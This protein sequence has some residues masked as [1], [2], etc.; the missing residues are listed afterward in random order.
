MI[1]PA[2]ML[3]QDSQTF[4]HETLDTEIL[5]SERRRIS[6]VLAFLAVACLTFTALTFFPGFLDDSIRLKFLAQT[7]EVAL[8]FSIALGY[9][10]AVLSWIGKLLREGSKPPHWLRYANTFI[11]NV[12]P[13]ATLLVAS[14]VFGPVEALSAA[15]TRFYFLFITMTALQLDFKVCLVAGVTAAVQYSAAAWYLLRNVDR[16]VY[17]PLLTDFVHQL[18]LSGLLLLAGLAA[19]FVASQI[20][21]QVIASLQA[22]EDRNRTIGIFGQY[23]SPQVVEKILRQP[24]GLRGELRGVSVLFLDI[25]NFSGYAVNHNPEEVMSYLNLLFGSMVDVVNQHHGIVNKFL[26]DGFMAIFG[27]PLDDFRHCTHAVEAGFELLAIVQRM[28]D[29]GEIPRTR[30][31]IGIHMGEVVTGNVGSTSRKEYTI[32]GDVVNLASRIESAC[33]EFDAQMLVSAEVMR[34]I[35]PSIPGNDLGPV[36]LK[37]QAAP[38][39]LHKLV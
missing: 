38:L 8:L 14:T 20:R 22:T 11:E 4:L 27:A 39:R 10:G 29:K 2:N 35:D 16:A 31:G 25:R 9:E 19:G 30:I 36:L 23:V 13:T 7:P 28:N 32:I 15:P 1:H 26:G 3:V 33:K 18:A 24:V 34:H 12:M 37:G 5:R 6:L 17:P 21:R